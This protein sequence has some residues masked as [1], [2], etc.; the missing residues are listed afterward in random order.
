MKQ[1]VSPFL[2]GLRSDGILWQTMKR[3][4][5]ALTCRL[6]TKFLGLFVFLYEKM[7]RKEKMK[8]TTPA[9]G[10]PNTGCGVFTKTVVRE[11]NKTKTVFLAHSTQLA[12][13]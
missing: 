2:V 12:V 5:S 4:P 1:P 6:P 3:E 8:K 11:K 7:K 9:I 13:Q 10:I